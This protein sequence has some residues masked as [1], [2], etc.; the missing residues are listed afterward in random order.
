MELEAQGLRKC[1]TLGRFPDPEND[2]LPV[3]PSSQE[4]A[5]RNRLAVVYPGLIQAGV[6]GVVATTE[7][8][9]TAE[10]TASLPSESTAMPPLAAVCIALEVA[11]IGGGGGALRSHSRKGAI[12]LSES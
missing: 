10:L 11:E 7:G 8:C 5:P 3:H 6:E 2:R 12:S 9:P 4:V 1:S